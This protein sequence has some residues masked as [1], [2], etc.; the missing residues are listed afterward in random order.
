MYRNRL[1]RSFGFF[2]TLFSLVALPLFA[3]QHIDKSAKGQQKMYEEQMND[4]KLSMSQMMNQ[5]QQM[6][7]QSETMMENMH[8]QKGMGMMGNQNH[9]EMMMNGKWIPSIKRE[10]KIWIF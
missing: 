5:M 9:Q 10:D 8:G 1:I 7:A 4:N 2:I 3:R 6:M